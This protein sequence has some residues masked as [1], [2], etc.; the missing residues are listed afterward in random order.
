MIKK[1]LAVFIV[2]IGIALLCALHFTYLIVGMFNGHLGPNPIETLTHQTGEWGLH[3]LLIGL[4]ITPLRRIFG[5]NVLQR[6]RRIVGVCSFVYIFSHF[7]IY[8]V[9]D[10]FFDVQTIVEDIVERPYITLGFAGLLL[11]IPLALTS[12]DWAQRRM[13]KRWLSLHRSVY[14]V[15][16]LGALHYIWLTK[17]DFL[18]P[19]IY[20]VVLALLLS[21]RVF[22]WGKK[23]GFWRA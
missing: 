5:W 4:A 16:I 13:G 3:L 14:A 17:A 23:K 19:I 12:F 8:L 21:V 22:F 11:I 18:L 2:K 7:M 10:H 6:F 15:A 20:S 1:P 9:F